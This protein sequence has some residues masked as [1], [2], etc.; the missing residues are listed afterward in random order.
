MQNVN[1]SV[2]FQCTSNI[3]QNQI[4]K[5][6]AHKLDL[7][8]K[9]LWFQSIQLRFTP[10]DFRCKKALLFRKLS[11]YQINW[12]RFF[13]KWYISRKKVKFI[14]KLLICHQNLVIWHKISL[15]DVTST[16]NKIE[17]KYEIG[18]SAGR[19]WQFS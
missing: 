12:H 10:S 17:L 15:Y 7:L 8:G 6:Q 19:F 2:T 13:N 5:I 4:H 16:L 3:F 14:F 1:I 9:I 18:K 11:K